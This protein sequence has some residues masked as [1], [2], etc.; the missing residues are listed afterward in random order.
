MS[1]HCRWERTGFDDNNRVEL[2]A[3]GILRRMV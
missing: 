1:A 2:E 3:A